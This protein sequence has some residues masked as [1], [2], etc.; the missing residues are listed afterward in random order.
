VT[1]K[2]QSARPMALA[3]NVPP[4]MLAAISAH[5]TYP[6]LFADAFGD[7]AISAERIAMAIAT[8]ERTLVADQ[9]P[10][11][12][13][14]R[15][16]PGAMTPAQVRGMN[17]FN[18][19]GRCNLCHAPG[20]FSDQQFRN[21]GL[22]PIAEDNGRQAVT[23]N[24]ADRGKFKV[25]SLRN[26]GLRTSFMHTGQFTSIQ[27][28]FGF[29]LGGG[30]P[31]LNNKDPLLLPLQVPPQS[32]S[33]LIDFVTNALVDPRVRNEQFPFDR[34]TLAGQRIPPLGF[35]FGPGSPGTGGLVPQV[36][37]EVPPNVG[38][39]DF[40]VGIGQARGGAPAALVVS[41]SAAPPGTQFAGVNLN[42]GLP[43]LL[44]LFTVLQGT[45]GLAG[46]GF[47]TF[48]V[49]LPNDPGLAGSTLFVQWFAVDPLAP[50][51]ASSSRG[52]EIR[53][54]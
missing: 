9:T 12:Q 17:V 14:Q 7:A 18:G 30:G 20:L 6:D 24:F 53:F 52:A 49:P 34:P 41:A 16:V 35:L 25:P 54:F 36:L 29:Y 8:Y 4:D 47:G 19:P 1:A 43:E 38:N 22:R 26:A 45:S 23:G 40:K 46:T 39:V 21:L 48:L 28:V 15:G 5:P 11:D 3:T 31:N 10:W 27:Q 51:G 44:Q 42:L 13:F 50:A 33:D 37:A 2:L 32:A